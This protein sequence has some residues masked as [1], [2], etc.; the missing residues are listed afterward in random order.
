MTSSSYRYPVRRGEL[1]RTHF[2]NR[3]AFL[4]S[5]LR[6]PGAQMCQAM[7]TIPGLQEPVDEHDLWGGFPWLTP[8]IGS[9]CLELP[10]TTNFTAERLA[11]LVRDRAEDVMPAVGGPGAPGLEAIALFAAEFTRELVNTRTSEA[12]RAPVEGQSDPEVTDL[13]VRMVVLAALL[14]R[15]FYLVRARSGTA[16]SRWEDDVAKLPYASRTEESASVRVLASPRKVAALAT[17]MIWAVTDDLD[18]ADMSPSVRGAT[19]TLLATIRE[20]LRAPSGKRDTPTTLRLDHLR[21]VTELAWYFLHERSPVYPGWTDLLIRMML[22]EGESAHEA[23]GRPRPRFTTIG[24]LPT[25]VEH[26]LSDVTEKSWG[27]YEPTSDDPPSTR[28][29]L[30]LAVADVLW[31]QSDALRGMSKEERRK[32]PIASAF[33]TSFD[34]EL[35]MALLATSAGRTFYVAVPVHVL[36]TKDS[37][38]AAFCWLVA[39]VGPLG[40]GPWGNSWPRCASRRT[41]AC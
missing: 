15:F 3:E 26:L 34:L 24:E 31:A 33:V 22:Q 29:R 25:V 8:V 19:S 23:S 13:A 39:E 9:G 38:D 21:L 30:Y 40:D 2:P 28:D 32:L 41:G 11:Q 5:T 18:D 10:I 12:Q 1:R 14:T 4:A 36:E 20:G 35:D 7:H 37:N 17:E 6:F 16:L 27:F